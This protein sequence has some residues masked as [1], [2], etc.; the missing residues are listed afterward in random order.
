MKTLWRILVSVRLSVLL[1]VWLCFGFVAATFFEGGTVFFLSSPFF[2]FPA[3]VFFINLLAC[4]IA[5]FARELRKPSSA[6][7]H[8]P[9][10]L[11]FGLLILFLGGAV[12]SAFRT[13][14]AAVLRVGDSV[15]L[16]GSEILTLTAFTDERYPDGRPKAWTSVV[17]V[18][19]GDA[20]LIAERPIRVNQP[21]RVGSLV[22]YQYSFGTELTAEVIGPRMQRT[23][24][25]EGES[26][27]IGD[28]SVHFFAKEG[29][30][31]ARMTISG[32]EIAETF[33][34]G[35]EER[36]NI[37][38]ITIAVRALP[39][40]GIQAV[41]DPGFPMV[42]LGFLLIALGTII[43]FVQKMRVPT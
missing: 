17:D 35:T 8:G 13:E 7:R 30:D 16:P 42:L 4:S 31:K 34:I 29:T 6:R 9:E 41:A 19:K 12:S 2:L 43:T 23:A 39:T 24:L 3:T 11:H 10:L 21:L 26:A 36:R 20:V 18:R 33:V 28:Y 27:T 40:S 15:T 1:M 25:A 37:G 5:R 22:L 32:P 14:G 38:Q